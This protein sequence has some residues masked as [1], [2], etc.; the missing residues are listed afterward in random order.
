MAWAGSRAAREE[1][2]VLQRLLVTLAP[3]VQCSGNFPLM[4]CMDCEGHAVLWVQAPGTTC[5]AQT[6]REPTWST[7]ARRSRRSMRRCWLRLRPPPRLSCPEPPALMPSPR[8][9]KPSRFGPSVGHLVIMRLPVCL[10]GDVLCWNMLFCA[11][12]VDT[13][14]QQRLL[15]LKEMSGCF[16][17]DVL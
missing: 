11:V 9:S 1:Q 16:S 7:P 13:R 17:R 2:E 10:L 6:W 12:S 14:R 3:P 8:P 5:S 4:P 15:R